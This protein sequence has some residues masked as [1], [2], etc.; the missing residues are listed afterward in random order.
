[1]LGDIVVVLKNDLSDNG[2]ELVV[3]AERLRSLG[4]ETKFSKVGRL[5]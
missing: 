3:L 2:E 5:G 4:M 1:M